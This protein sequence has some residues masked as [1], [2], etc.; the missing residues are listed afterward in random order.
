MRNIFL[1]IRRHSVLLFFVLLQVICLS[2]LV[3]YNKSYEAKYMQAASEVTGFVN[4][5]VSGITGFFSLKENNKIL[6][7][8]NARLRN[9]LKQNFSETQFADSV[10][11]DSTRIDSTFKI[12]RFKWLNAPVVGNSTSQQNNYIQLGRGSNQGI[13]A[14][15]AVVSGGNVVGLVTDVSNNFSTVMSLL[16]RKSL[17]SVMLH[18]NKTLGILSWDG[19]NPQIMQVKQIPRSEKIAI[20]DTII[21][22]NV[23]SNY[24]EGLMIGT[25][26]KVED[27]KGTNNFLLQ[28]KPKANFSTLQFAEVVENLFAEEQKALMEK[29]KK[30]NL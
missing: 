15:M 20:G 29:T 5:K 19:I 18:K 8:E 27:D 25:V 26:L 10:V 6:A 16:H 14:G 22:S 9:L 24:P 12:R 2:M 4:N 11:S 30:Q 3:K 13:K 28:I 17:T 1:F 23:S 7:E 21:T